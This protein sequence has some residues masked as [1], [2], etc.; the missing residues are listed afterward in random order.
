MEIINNRYQKLD[1]LGEG[2]YGVV[3]QALDLLHNTHQ[4]IKK[5]RMEDDEDEGIP[6]TT[7][8]E[9]SVLR[10]L[11]HPNIVQLNDIILE[12]AKIYLIFDFHPMDLRKY[13]KNLPNTHR[14]LHFYQEKFFQL[15]SAIDYC[16]SRGILHRDLKP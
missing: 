13:L 5:I 15:L 12:E 9:I 2:T 7:L 14:P 6:A 10:H 4:A 8:R 16:H 3:F 11:K 1:K